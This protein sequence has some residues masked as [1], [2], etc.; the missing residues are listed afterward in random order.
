MK[1]WKYFSSTD[2]SINPELLTPLKTINFHLIDKFQRYFEKLFT[3][4]KIF[5]CHKNLLK[6]VELVLQGL[7][8][9][10]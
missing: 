3:D 10:K 8:S 9:N 4:M 7:I 5:L 6:V 1:T 2:N